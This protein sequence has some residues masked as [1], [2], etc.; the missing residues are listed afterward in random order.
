MTH[1]PA[2]P[3]SDLPQGFDVLASIRRLIA[4]DSAHVPHHHRVVHAPV[5]P[6][7]RIRTPDEEPDGLGDAAEP[8]LVLDRADL[9]ER[10]RLSPRLHLGEVAGEA[11]HDLPNEDVDVETP[12]ESAAVAP[13]DLPHIGG[14]AGPA[15]ALA[16]DCGSEISESLCGFHSPEAEPA[17]PETCDSVAEPRVYDLAQADFGL[18]AEQEELVA[19]P[20]SLQESLSPVPPVSTADHTPL[21]RDRSEAIARAIA[22]P[23]VNRPATM[24]RKPAR[25]DFD[26]DMNLHLFAPTDSDLPNGSV[27]R[28]LI[29]EVIRQEL[30]GE[31]G[32]RFSRNLRTVIRQEIAAALEVQVMTSVHDTRPDELQ[33]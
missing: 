33:Q 31:M 2:H 10:I 16:E 23:S 4:Q 15:E 28:N 13:D 18:G 5:A 29:R 24:P 19:A 27:L 30:H 26:E 17:A 9:I 21:Q 7:A 12:D 11:M 1:H 14:E 25:R 8:R 20:E 22:R 6:F 32:G 3:Q